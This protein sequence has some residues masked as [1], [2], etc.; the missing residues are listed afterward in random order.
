MVCW[1]NLHEKRTMHPNLKYL[2]WKSAG[3]LFRR[4]R[5]SFLFFQLLTASGLFAQPFQVGHRQLSFSDSAR[6]GRQVNFELYY[7]AETTGDDVPPAAGQFPVLAFGHGFVMP[8]SVYGVY[9]QSLVP[10]GYIMAF[11][12]TEGSILP[13]HQNFGQDLAFLCRKLRQEGASPQSA[14]FNRVSGKCAVM[15]HSMGGGASF[16]ALQSDTSISAMLSLAAANTNPPSITAAASVQKPSLVISGANDCVAPQDVHQIPMYNALAAAEKTLVSIS[17][18]DHCQ[19][20]AS[21]FNCNLGQSTCS[22][23]AAI[24][25]QEQ[26][27]LTV[28]YLLPWLDFYLKGKCE[29]ALQFQDLLAASVGITSQQVSPLACSTT[30]SPAMKMRKQPAV[31]PNPASSFIEVKPP[32]GLS[33]GIVRI[34]NVFGKE[35]QQTELV[36]EQQ[37][38]SIRHLP[39]GCYYL[40]INDLPAAVFIRQ[41]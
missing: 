33:S 32:G 21:N 9:W 23:Q 34:R 31:F 22:P 27:N 36:S 11:P 38:I 16:L 1:P 26:Q 25:R 40:S 17:G 3:F 24:S 7:P 41:D 2:F 35:I 14:F 4:L 28:S 20:A 12:T 30:F 19:F 37:R 6:S 15:G 29:A 39:A 13:S 10:Q 8:W 18:A 5:G